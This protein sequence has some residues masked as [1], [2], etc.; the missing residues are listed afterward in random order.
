MGPSKGMIREALLWCLMDKLG[1]TNVKGEKARVRLLHPPA[2]R[3]TEVIVWELN[4][5]EGIRF[6]CSSIVLGLKT[7]GFSF[8]MENIKYFNLCKHSKI[9]FRKK[10]SAWGGSSSAC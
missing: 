4:L 6:K 9:Y 8:L 7:Q 3:T 2:S 10:E 1:E 5:T